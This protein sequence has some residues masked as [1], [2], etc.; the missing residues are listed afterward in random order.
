M[1]LSV[2]AMKPTIAVFIGPHTGNT[3]RM[4]KPCTKIIATPTTL[5][6]K[7]ISRG[8]QSNFSI[9]KNAQILG[10]EKWPNI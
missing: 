2:V 1:K 8:D 10:S 7:P 4:R 9:V 5:N 3:L 6:E